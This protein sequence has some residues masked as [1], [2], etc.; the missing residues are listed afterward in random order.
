MKFLGIDKVNEGK[1]LTKYDIHYETALGNEKT[2]EMISRSKNLHSQDDLHDSPADSVVMIVTD[3]TG[4]HLLLSREFRL[5]IGCFI[6]GFP[7]GLIDPG[8]TAVESARRELWE[9]T[10]LDLVSIDKTFPDSYNCVGVTNEKSTCIFGKAEGTFRASTS[11]VEEIECGWY[12]K[13]QVKALL[14]T[15]RFSARTQMVCYFWANRN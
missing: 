1:F 14:E 6:Y 10:G 12:T 4:E 5:A 13:E 15:E 8:E 9:E 7:A 2:Y 3:K 11:D